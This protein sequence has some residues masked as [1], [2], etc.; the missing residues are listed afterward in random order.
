[1]IDFKFDSIKKLV[2]TFKTEADCYKYLEQIRWGNGIIA[3][4]AEQSMNLLITGG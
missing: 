1:M 2:V 4:S 3:Q